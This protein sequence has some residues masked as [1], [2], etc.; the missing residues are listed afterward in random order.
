SA[1][2][3]GKHICVVN[4]HLCGKPCKFMGRHGCLDACTKVIG[5]PDE[6]HLC[7]APVHAC[8]RPCDL[9]GVKLIDGST[10]ACPGSCR[11]ASDLD[12]FRHE[13]D[14]RF[15]SIPCQLCKRLC[16]DQDHMHGLESD[17][18]H[19]CGQE[20]LCTAV[21]SSPGICEIETAPQSIEATFTG[22]NETFQYTKVRGIYLFLGSC[23][24][25]RNIEIAKRLKCMK[26]IAPGATEHIGPHNHSLDKK[27]VHFCEDRCENC[28]YF[29]TLP[30]GH[31]QQEHETR[32]GSMSRTRWAVD[33]PDDVALE[34]EGRKFSTNDEGAPM[35]CNLVCQAM[36]RHVHIDYCRADDE[37]ACAGND[38]L[39]HLT[40][41]MQPNPDRPKDVLT[42]NLFWKRSGFRDPYSKE[43]QTNFAK[44]CVKSVSSYLRIIDDSAVM[45]CVADLNTVLL[46][47]IRPCLHTVFCHFSILL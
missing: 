21:C 29:C 12:H 43:E 42:H 40:K 39:Q 5:H 22:K 9:S 45:P 1:G 11:I 33:G 19:L 3:A 10:Y 2:H 6:E 46:A 24:Y 23:S 27:V 18:I 8:G 37:A 4:E 38:E 26:P 14:A 7:A 35:M 47:E 25:Q 15:C 13:C 16:S 17:A 28:G 31:P 44:W 32:H 20:H 41:R 30:L 34:I 36:G